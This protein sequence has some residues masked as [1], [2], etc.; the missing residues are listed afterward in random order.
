MKIRRCAVLFLEPREEVGFDLQELLNGGDGLRRERRW[1]ALAPHLGE[2]VEVDADERELLGVLSPSQWIDASTLAA[3]PPAALQ[4]LL[5]E[6]LLIGDDKRHAAHRACDEALRAAY[7]HPLAATLHAFTRWSGVDAVQNMKDSGTETA[8]QMREVLGAPPVEAARRVDAPSQLKLPRIAATGFDQLLARRVTCRN[9]DP[10]RALPF[11][12]F[13]QVMQRVFAAQAEVRVSED[14]VFLKKNVPSGGGLHPIECYLIVQNVEDVAPGLYHYQAVE[15]ALEPLPLPESLRGM[16]LAAVASGA[17]EVAGERELASAD[18]PGAAETMA[19]GTGNAV[20]A[21]AAE[22]AAVVADAA[23]DAHKAA[24][25][26]MAGADGRNA[27]EA[28]AFAGEGS[29]P[30]PDR[31]AGPSTEGGRRGDVTASPDHAAP[32]A[33]SALRQFIQDM[34]AQQHW[35]ADAHVVVVLAPRF[36]RTF[37]KYRQ[38]AK[39]YRVVALEAGHLSQTLYLAATDAGLGAFITG[40]I[41]EKELERAFGLDHVNQGALAICGFGWRGEA[42]VTAELDPRAEVWRAG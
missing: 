31:S 34:V 21:T 32:I 1:V 39:G 38:H 24:V 17:S 5:G 42:M 26:V 4:R 35:F 15:H 29:A 28:E 13:A 2:E 41:N 3:P 25:V 11:E 14:T 12:L 36:D 37:W 19:V 33:A 20:A 30:A 27:S 18:A 8:V 40:A 22:P 9:F 6:G 10:A 23:N 16:T 7:W